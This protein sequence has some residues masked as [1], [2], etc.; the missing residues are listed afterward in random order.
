MSRAK[1]RASVL[2]AHG[3]AAVF[4]DDGLLVVALHVRQRL[5]QDAGAARAG[6]RSWAFGHG[7]R[8]LWRCACER[9]G[10]SSRSRHR[11]ASAIALAVCRRCAPS[12]QPGDRGA[13]FGDAGAGRATRSPA[14]PGKA[15]GRLASAA[16]VS[17]DAVGELGGLHLVGLGQHDLVADRG[18]VERRR[19]PA[20]S[21]VL[22]A[23]AGV[24]QHIDAARDWRGRADRR[25]S[26]RSRPRP[27]SWRL[28]HSRS[29]ACRPASSAAAAGEEDQLL[30]AARRVRGARQRLAAGQRVDQAR[31]ADIGAAGKGDLDAA[32]RRQ[33][34]DRAGGRRRN[35]QSPAN[36]LRPASISARVKS[37]VMSP[38]V[39]MRRAAHD[40][41]AQ[42]LVVFFFAEQSP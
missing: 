1:S 7:D 40:G 33:R 12:Q 15:A 13:Q 30:G 39:V 19:A 36:S 16:S 2:L 37:A 29:P 3:V 14:P 25:G 38:G 10:A 34:V 28:R 11:A 6:D 4:D 8:R 24:D 21:V 35:C 5:R 32:H 26:A 17:R 42:L 31:L 23:V 27:W 20:S 22:E 9:T 18:L 41:V